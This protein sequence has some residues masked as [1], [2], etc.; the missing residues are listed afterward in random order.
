MSH[1][2]FDYKHTHIQSKVALLGP[3]G[4]IRDRPVSKRRDG[5]Q[6]SGTALV[7]E[8]VSA[9]AS[10]GQSRAAVADR[11]AARRVAERLKVTTSAAV[12]LYPQKRVRL[13][14]S[15]Y[16]IKEEPSLNL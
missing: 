11:H 8:H 9:E 7:T 12:T 14:K 13:Y 3:P 16:Y 1:G 10:T 6:N 2:S 15:K 4:R 5:G